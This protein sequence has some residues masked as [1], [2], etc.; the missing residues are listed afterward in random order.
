MNTW[1]GIQA[2]TRWD[3][4]VVTNANSE[5]LNG[6]PVQRIGNPTWHLSLVYCGGGSSCSVDITPMVF[7]PCSLQSGATRTDCKLPMAANLSTLDC[8]LQPPRRT[9][10]SVCMGGD[11]GQHVAGVV[12]LVRMTCHNAAGRCCGT[13]KSKLNARDPRPGEYPFPF[14]ALSYDFSSCTALNI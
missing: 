4:E 11:H 12:H 1:M 6:S 13:P 14:T 3:S 9:F 2:M 10:V 7:S 5:N 8:I